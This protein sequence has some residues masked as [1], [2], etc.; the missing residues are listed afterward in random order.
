MKF[1]SSSSGD[2][3]LQLTVKNTQMKYIWKLTLVN[4]F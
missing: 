3:F 2:V 4:S 1:Y